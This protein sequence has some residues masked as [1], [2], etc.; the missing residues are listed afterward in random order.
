MGNLSTVPYVLSH[1]G[2]FI[3][4]RIMP[5]EKTFLSAFFSEG[6]RYNVCGKDVSKALKM[7]ATI[8][9]YPITWGIPIEQIDTRSLRSGGVNALALSGYLDAQIQK[10]SRWKG[11]TFKEYI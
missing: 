2:S 11:A 1:A 7:A 4:T 8:L 6:A 3:C 9:Q 10:M 5:T